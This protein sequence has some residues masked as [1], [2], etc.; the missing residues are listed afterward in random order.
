MFP[1]LLQIGDF[2]LATYGV[3]MVA[4]YMASI[5]YLSAKRSKLGLDEAGFSSLIC[6]LFFGAIVGAKLMYWAVEWR[7]VLSGA[8]R[9]LRDF[10]YGVV[11]YGGFFG[12]ALT[13]VVAARRL[14]IP[15][16]ASAD[17]VAAAL[18]LGHGIG[19]LGC[20]AAGCCSGTLASVPWALRFTH[21]D[22]LVPAHLHGRPLHPVQLYEA[23]GDFAIA[24]AMVRLIGRIERKTLAPGTAALAYVL[25]YAA[26]RFAVEFF[27]GDDRGGFF[28]G[29][30]VS[31]WAALACMGAAGGFLVKRGVKV[32]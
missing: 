13:G 27:R 16:L 14:K 17:Y 18:P 4:G 20:L 29:L 19:R 7:G 5:W 8:V 1:T 21:P 2:R 11:F 10:R 23:F 24:A 31:Q 15:Y 9:P 26:L 28:V 3:L 6:W 30:S 12:A 32:R 22:A 25:C